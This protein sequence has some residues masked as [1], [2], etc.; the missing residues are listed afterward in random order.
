MQVKITETRETVGDMTQAYFTFYKLATTQP[1]GNVMVTDNTTGII[2]FI[3]ENGN[4]AYVDGDFMRDYLFT[5][6]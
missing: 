4:F 2:L 5:L 6:D 3:Y 1:A